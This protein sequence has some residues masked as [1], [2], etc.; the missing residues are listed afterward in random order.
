MQL[1]A[2]LHLKLIL[3]RKCRERLHDS[4]GNYPSPQQSYPKDS[5]ISLGIH[6]TELAL[7]KVNAIIINNEPEPSECSPMLTTAPPGSHPYG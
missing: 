4:L 2:C 6:F 7:F 1:R 3:N 5:E